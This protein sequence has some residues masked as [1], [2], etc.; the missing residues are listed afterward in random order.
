[1][2][3][4]ILRESMSADYRIKSF[5]NSGFGGCIGVRMKDITVIICCYNSEKVL[6]HT[7]DC[8]LKQKDLEKYV[9]EIIVVD[10]NSSDRTSEIVKSY[11]E[12]KVPI[13]YI[14]ESKQGLSN[15]R[16]AGIM[17]SS[18]KWI[19]FIDDD[20]FLEDNWFEN[21]SK[22]ISSHPDV[23]VFNG[24][25]IPFVD[26]DL[27][28][29]ERRRLKASLKVL[30]CTHYDERD[31]KTNPKTPFRNPIGAGM[32]ILTEPLEKLIENGWLNS[33]GRT[34]DNLTSGEDG[35]M[36]Y[37]V[38]NQGYEFGFCHYA[39]IRHRM[40]R[41]R[42][43]DEYLNRM[44]YEIGK[45]VAIVAREQKKNVWELIVYRILLEIR[46][47]VYG[48]KDPYLGKYYKRYVEGY[49]NEF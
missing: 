34:K 26:F 16:K 5:D 3:E 8:L 9:S 31:V 28:E 43:S 42:L 36:A 2:S 35:E 39:L 1:M 11:V 41:E 14:F 15:A 30:A 44:W 33:S 37:W 22:Y 7:I 45:G 12:E 13:R 19:A 29:E 18:T 4:N 47:I 27:S 21:V 25:V 38:K 40:T 49:V 48:I 20:N 17:K 6:P 10:N 46:K 32:M 24:A 23:G